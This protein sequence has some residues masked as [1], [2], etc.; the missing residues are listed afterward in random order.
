MDNNPTVGIT[1][2]CPGIFSTN[3]ILILELIPEIPIFH[4]MRHQQPRSFLW[5]T[6]RVPGTAGATFRVKALVQV[7][8]FDIHLKGN[9]DM[10]VAWRIKDAG[11]VVHLNDAVYYERH[12]NMSTLKDLCKTYIEYGY[13]S[14]HLYRK[15]KK[16]FSLPRMSPL[17]GFMAGFFYS[18]ICYRF[19]HRKMV[20]LLPFHFTLK[21]T[22]W[23]LGFIKSQIMYNQLK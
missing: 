7:K 18:L 12:G 10:D 21:M 6:E 11:W 13:T 3:R 15:N 2:G 14:Y 19:Q 20:F 4:R 5:K 22:A 9:E 8:G 17:A 16:N 23:C 1:A